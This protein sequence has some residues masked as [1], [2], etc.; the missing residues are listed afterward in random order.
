MSWMD[1]FKRG[2][3]QKLNWDERRRL[4]RDKVVA[5]AEKKRVLSPLQDRYEEL[6]KRDTEL[7]RTKRKIDDETR[8]FNREIFEYDKKL[9]ASAPKEIDTRP[10]GD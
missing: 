5:E 9:K 8:R 3:E 7:E 6:L 1:I 2:D 10:R 4:L